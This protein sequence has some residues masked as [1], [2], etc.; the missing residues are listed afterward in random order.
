MAAN[1]FFILIF[2][3]LTAGILSG[4]I[5][6]GGGVVMIPMMVMML[7][8]DQKMAQGT[9]IAIMLPPIGILAVYNYYKE[10]YVNI[11]FAAVIAA[12]F[13][14]GGFFGSKLAIALPAELVKKIFAVLLVAIA[15]KM[16]FSK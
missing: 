2:I 16:F 12:A 14:I 6:L 1:T 4:M 13:I 8:M 9:S 3:G 15:V 10:G 11:K 5:G 7:A